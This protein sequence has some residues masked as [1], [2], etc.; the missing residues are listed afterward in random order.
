MWCDSFCEKLSGTGGFGWP[1]TYL[2]GCS[3]DQ[4][5]N[6]KDGKFVFLFFSEGCGGFMK[7][8]LK[9]FETV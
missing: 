6:E 1:N 4:Q 2:S 7:L 8:V 3:L 9:T 5:G